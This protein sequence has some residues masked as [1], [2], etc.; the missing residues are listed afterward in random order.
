MIYQFFVVVKG[1]LAFRI[2]APC[3]FIAS[4]IFYP[5]LALKVSLETIFS[6]EEACTDI[7]AVLQ[8]L[9]KEMVIKPSY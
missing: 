9:L 4:L 7:A 6:A 8:R 5:V 2:D 1:S 3:S